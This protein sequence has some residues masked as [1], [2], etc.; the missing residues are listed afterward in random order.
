MLLRDDLDMDCA[1]GEEETRMPGFISRCYYYCIVC[2]GYK[3]PC[4]QVCSHV[5]ELLLVT[6]V[7]IQTKILRKI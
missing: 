2:T 1:C 5:L 6:F 7:A 3:V 4:R